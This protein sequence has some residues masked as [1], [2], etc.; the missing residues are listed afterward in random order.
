MAIV[1]VVVLVA[2]VLPRFESFFKDFHAKLPFATR[3]LLNT[4]RFFQSTW[5]ILLAVGA[6]ASS[7]SGTC[8]SARPRAGSRATG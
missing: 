6:P 3:L 8:T 1:T 4:S 2:F 7:W 5:F